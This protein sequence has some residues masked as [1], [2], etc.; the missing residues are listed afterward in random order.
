MTKLEFVKILNETV[1]YNGSN[2]NACILVVPA[3]NSITWDFNLQAPIGD[4]IEDD[5][6]IYI[7]NGFT[8]T[9]NFDNR[10]S[11]TEVLEKLKELDDNAKIVF[12]IY[13]KNKETG[14]N[15]QIVSA[16]ISNKDDF[17]ILESNAN[18]KINFVIS[19]DSI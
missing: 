3:I 13:A 10:K 19:V 8:N 18:N 9:T 4:I 2:R 17:S 11:F 14:A 6:Y 16:P 5:G 12:E 15:E 1:F 7:S